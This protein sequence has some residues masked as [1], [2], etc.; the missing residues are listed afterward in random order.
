MDEFAIHLYFL[1]RFN[2]GVILIRLDEMRR[3]NWSQRWKLIAERDLTTLYSTQL[4]DQD[5][6]NAV[7]KVGMDGLLD[8]LHHNNPYPPHIMYMH[9]YMSVLHVKLSNYFIFLILDTESSLRVEF[10]IWLPMGV[11]VDKWAGWGACT[12][13]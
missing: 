4:A 6:I 10:C 8:F 7:V 1:V 11:W 13:F 9:Y 5:I 12:S 2:T 3:S